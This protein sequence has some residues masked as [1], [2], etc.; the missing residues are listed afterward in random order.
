MKKQEK[1]FF[2]DNLTAEIKSAKS[3]VLINFTGMSV[4]V[5]QELKRRLKE[6]GAKM[7]VVKNTLLK[8]AGEAASVDA[9]I[10]ENTILTGQTALIVSES[11]PVSPIQVLGKFAKEFEVP[12]LKV[13]IVE[14]TF[15][16]SLSLS[17]ISNL[18]GRDGLLGQLLGAL[19]GPIYGL[20]GTL[21]GNLQKLVFV[22]NSKASSQ[23]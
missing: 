8:R 2:V 12:E 17:R 15:Q 18:P 14:G 9:G 11:D 16:D 7:I 13:G 21:G 6:V 22:L 1:I 19:M 5:Q 23:N 20:T 3:L 4:K 10:L